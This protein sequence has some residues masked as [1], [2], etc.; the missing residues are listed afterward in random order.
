MKGGVGCCGE[1]RAE[2]QV[3]RPGQ[4]PQSGDDNLVPLSAASL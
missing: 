2:K 3:D 4:A 1:E